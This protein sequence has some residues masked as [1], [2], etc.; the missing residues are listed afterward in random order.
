MLTCNAIAIQNIQAKYAL[1]VD[2]L[3][4][5]E[6]AIADSGCTSHFLGSNARCTNKQPCAAGVTVKLPNS[7]SMVASH[8][9]LLDMP[10]LPPEARRCHIFPDMGDKALLSIAQ[11]CDNGYRVIF[12]ADALLIEHETDPARSFQGCRDPIT[13]M[14]TI[15]LSQVVTIPHL[16]K[17]Q[18][19]TTDR[20][21]NNV[22]DFTL[23]RDIVRYLHRA[24]GSPVPSTWCAAIDKGNYATWAGLTAPLVKK[25]LP[26]SVATTKGHMRQ[27]RQNLRSTKQKHPPPSAPPSSCEMTTHTAK[28]SVR[29]NM[30]T[31]QCMSVSGN[32]FQIK[33]GDSP[34]NQAR[35]ISTSWL[36]TTTTATQSLLS[37]SRRAQQRRYCRQ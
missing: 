8:T 2:V 37:L 31:V 29:E 11:F 27:I 16:E 10:H 26:K 36:H 17:K 34:T 35:G 23:K 30:I 9:A 14:W 12:T 1:A 6:K 7:M 32:F 28:E 18:Y 21:A 22:Y 25:H 19:T 24:A 33:R 5:N 13:N 20:Q 4:S 15:N 3:T